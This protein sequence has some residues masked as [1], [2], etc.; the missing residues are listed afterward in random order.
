MKGRILVT[1]AAGFIGSHLVDFLRTKYPIHKVIGITRKDADLTRKRQVHRLL[2]KIRPS[3][4]VHAAGCS[5]G[6]LGDLLEMNVRTTVNIL[7]CVRET[8]P[9]IRIILIASAAEYGRTPKPGRGTDLFRPLTPYGWSKCCQTL[10]GLQAARTGL[11][12]VVGRFFNLAGP[13]LPS[14]YSLGTF[15][16]QI[17]HAERGDVRAIQVGD[18]TPTRDILDVRDAVMGLACLAVRGRSGRIYEICSGQSHTIGSLLRQ[19]LRMTNRPLSCRRYRKRLRSSDVPFSV[20]NPAAI[21]SLGWRPRV[22]LEQSL[23]DT[24]NHYR[25]RRD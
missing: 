13:G 19:L 18:L 5:K 22:P 6:T 2:L 8:N 24:L 12:I 21:R 9:R 16:Q 20:G 4:I 17:V 14:R 25:S 23:R 10:L 15:A 3:V 11:D 1:G 7:E